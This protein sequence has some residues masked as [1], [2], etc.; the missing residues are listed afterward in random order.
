MH[1]ETD[2]HSWYLGVEV[3]GEWEACV[4]ASRQDAVGAFEALRHDY[5]SALG[6]AFLVPEEFVERIRTSPQAL[7]PPWLN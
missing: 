1:T 2:T 4:F 6:R 5:R 3:D 7:P